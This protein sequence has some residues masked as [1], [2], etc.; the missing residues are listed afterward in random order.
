MSSNSEF[1]SVVLL[2]C[3]LVC[4]CVHAQLDDAM[5]NE[6]LTLHNKA[7]QSVQNGQLVGQPKAVSI[8]PL[9]WN[10]ELEKKAQILSDQCRVGHDT[11]ADRK[12][13]EFQY[14]GQNWAGAKNINTF[15]FRLIAI[16][17]SFLSSGFQLW[18]DEYKNYDFYTRTCRKGQCGHYTQ[19]V[20]ED[21]TDV[22]CGVTNCPNFPYGLSIVCN[23]GPG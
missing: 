2:V 15:M 19:L 23:Y 16:V 11:S 7:R 4:C 20:W 18:L 22:G 12:I 13:P 3:S 10:V 17:C 14:V 8:K 1:S 6:L 5:R 21:T 9:K